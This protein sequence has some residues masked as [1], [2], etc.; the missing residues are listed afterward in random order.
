MEEKLLKLKEID[1]RL[2]E[3]KGRSKMVRC[4]S[5]IDCSHIKEKY[6]IHSREW[7]AGQNESTKYLCDRKEGPMRT[8]P[9]KTND[10]YQ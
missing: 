10:D 8:V 4:D 3:R 9:W 1:E 5:T 7:Y 2:Q 6:P